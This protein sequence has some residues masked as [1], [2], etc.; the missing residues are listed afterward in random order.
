M[1]RAPRP[2]PGVVLDREA[3][4][5]ATEI[6]AALNQ[7]E[8]SPAEYE[9][10]AAY[11][12][13][14]LPPEA[15]IIEEI[16]PPT[17]AERRAVAAEAKAVRDAAEAAMPTPTPQAQAPMPPPPPTG[18]QSAA[19]SQAVS[20]RAQPRGAAA[21]T[22]VSQVVSLQERLYLRLVDERG[23]E[24]DLGD[25]GVQEIHSGGGD[26]AGFVRKWIAP[27]YGGGIFRAYKKARTG[28]IL[29]EE[30]NIARPTN[31]GGL[32]GAPGAVDAYGRPIG[33]QQP[34]VTDQANAFGSMT[35]AI[36][37]I[38]QASRTEAAEAAK[39]KREELTML[40]GLSNKG[41]DGGNGNGGGDM[42]EKMIMMK[43]LAP[44][45]PDT[46]AVERSVAE[47]A[48][49]L[50][51]TNQ[52]LSTA[53][54][55]LDQRLAQLA[56][57]PAPMPPPPPAPPDHAGL[58]AAIGTAMAP[59]LTAIAAVATRAPVVPPAPRDI[60]DYL[61]IIVSTFAGLKEAGIVGGT[62]ITA[63]DLELAKISAKLESAGQTKG[64]LDQIKD[65]MEIQA[66][67]VPQQNEWA[68]I[69]SQALEQLPDLMSG[70]NEA[71][72]I[73]KQ[74]EVRGGGKAKPIKQISGK[75]VEIPAILQTIRTELNAVDLDAM[76]NGDVVGQAGT[77]VAGKVV[78][79]GYVITCGAGLQ[80]AGDPWASWLDEFTAATCNEDEEAAKIALAR[81][82]HKAW[83]RGDKLAA[84]F[85]QKIIKVWTDDLAMIGLYFRKLLGRM[86]DEDKAATAEHAEA[87]EA[88]D[89]DEEL[90]AAEEAEPTTA[91]LL[92]D[93]DGDEFDVAAAE[94][95]EANQD[96]AAAIEA[97]LLNDLEA[98]PI[99]ALT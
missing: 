25:Y 9:S 15:D 57:A 62:K 2:K 98:D 36:Q 77:E 65:V 39:A 32:P 56:A 83:G 53:F 44:D 8:T 17:A 97:D 4:A 38:Q 89:T 46:S 10:A 87:D 29:A 34:T 82:V 72:R 35:N 76:Y 40:M 11:E 92:G 69:V 20:T 66:M 61:P 80:Q 95:D 1:P 96:E 67:M 37:S 6:Q 43:M 23:S 3:V 45:K 24:K 13:E 19:R 91:E 30:V 28:M 41:G 31:G 64:P 48:Q 52:G 63:T 71:A 70:M 7:E 99:E 47:L 73:K 49:G 84:A 68:V 5:L 58:V 85:F 90:E 27:H 59:V 93:L 55:Q 94:A 16:A 81:I 78:V 54:G 18:A 88:A 74:A 12:A 14:P 26:L 33:P 60:A 42:F 79:V 21:P 51:Q 75:K 22:K 86:T 50:G